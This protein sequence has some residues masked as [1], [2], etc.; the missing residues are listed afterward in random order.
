MNL[1]M[2]MLPYDLN[3]YIIFTNTAAP[4]SCELRAILVSQNFTW[5]KTSLKNMQFFLYNILCCSGSSM[6]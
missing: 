2:K 3:T 1:D 5:L 4:L 6:G